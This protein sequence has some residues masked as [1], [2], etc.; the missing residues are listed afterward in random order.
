MRHFPLFNH[1][2]EC[3][4]NMEE[5]REYVDFVFSPI[6]LIEILASPA[7]EQ[8]L[9]GDSPLG[10]AVYP[11]EESTHSERCPPKLAS[12]RAWETG[13]FPSPCSSAQGLYPRESFHHSLSAI[14]KQH[15]PPH[16]STRLTHIPPPLPSTAH[17]YLHFY[18]SHTIFY[19]IDIS[20]RLWA[21]VSNVS[22]S[23]VC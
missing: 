16:P 19:Y 21:S 20:H 4:I 10:S 22:F 23:A 15:P 3:Y 8:P 11:G 12:H 17:P 6:S 9:P 14:H 1:F 5:Q 7:L 13:V 18:I 2:P